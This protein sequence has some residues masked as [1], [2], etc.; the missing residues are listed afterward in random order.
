[1]TCDEQEL[2]RLRDETHRGE[3][4]LR[5][6]ES[7][8]AAEERVLER[9]LDDLRL[10]EECTAEGLAADYRRQHWHKDPPPRRY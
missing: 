5:R 7:K 4:A 6:A 9:R 10:E 2:D 8:L 1:M 3:F